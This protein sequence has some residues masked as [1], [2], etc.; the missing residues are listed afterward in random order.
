LKTDLSFVPENQMAHS[1][2]P[3]HESVRQHYSAQARSGQSCCN[4]G[5]SLYPEELIGAL[6]A[7]VTGFSLGC[8]NPITI[9]ELQPGETVLDLGSGGGLDC[10]LAARKVGGT[11]RVIGVD[12]APEMLTRARAS[13]VRLGA[14]NVEFRE[15]YLESL[16]VK[17]GS[18]DA[19]ISNCV[20]NLS[21]DKSQVFR[22]VFR[23]LKPGGRMAVSDV[24]T[25]GPLPD[26]IREDMDAWGA[27][28]AGALDVNEYTDGLKATGFV[29]V[30]VRPADDLGQ[31]LASRPQAKVFSA[32]VIARKPA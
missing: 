13:A 31:E 2:T 24:V 18:I 15:G 4:S 20:I 30:S 29:E 1:P 22:E 25:N 23:V 27:C 26:S 16:P 12:M 6:P 21:P 14:G 28:V 3:I 7:D 9:A 10:F 17:T 11:G 32:V 8:G 19:V 5:N